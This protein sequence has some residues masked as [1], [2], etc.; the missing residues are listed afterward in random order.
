MKIIVEQPS[1]VQKLF[2]KQTRQHGSKYR[3]FT[4]VISE[5]VDGGLLL[6]NVMTS[7]LILLEDFNEINTFNEL[8]NNISLQEEI[9]INTLI[10]NWFIVPENNDD[11]KIAKE[12]SNL[13]LMVNKMNL[14][15]YINHFKILP[16]TD[17][18][19]RCFYCYELNGN[20]R[21]MSE[22]TAH[23][24][25]DFIEKKSKKQD[26]T[27]S[28]FGGEPL[29]NS[30]AIDIICSDLKNKNITFK[31]NMVT[32]AYLF[33]ESNIKKAV[34]LWNLQR[35]Q[36]TLDGTEE[37]Y[38]RIKA[39]IYKGTNAF[40]I[41][42]N[43]IENL[44]NNNIYV[45][46]RMNMDEYNSEDLFALTN[47]LH[48]KFSTYD[49]FSMYSHTLF[50]ESSDKIKNRSV[51]DRQALLEKHIELQKYFSKL[52]YHRVKGLTSE[53]RV[54]HCQ[55]DSDNTTIIYPFGELGKC[56]HYTDDHFYGNIY[57]EKIDY[58]MI[59][60]FKEVINRTENCDYC[61]LRQWCLAPELCNGLP[62]R[63]DDFDKRCRWQSV[64]NQMKYTYKTFK[65][66]E[67]NLK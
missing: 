30:K 56:Q 32:N 22:K 55:C 9:L 58:N 10:S 40:K 65:E 62:R 43:N 59:N 26:V 27:L 19:A 24:V 5:E 6:Y 37:I 36:I 61:P 21:D 2:P 51:E 54:S 7:E 50:E 8:K 60:Q 11:V 33:D 63:C 52:G 46:V 16:T 67:A 49:K 64:K 17:C 29:Y 3:K 14:N 31:S 35:V 48:E 45:Q 53:S 39:Y 34:E 15:P 57:S 12:F 44:L 1:L 13:M 38:N 66:R 47:L 41:V 25:A 42:L 23:D 18:N 28:W 4:Y 20:R